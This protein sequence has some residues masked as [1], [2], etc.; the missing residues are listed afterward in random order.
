[1]DAVAMAQRSVGSIGF[2]VCKRE[3]QTVMARLYQAG[4]LRLRLVR[5]E[6]ENFATAVLLNTGGGIAGGD[7][8]DIDIATGIDT[9]L[10]IS[11]QGAE[12]VY[13]ASALDDPARIDVRL[14]VA[15]GAVV[16]FLPQETILFDQ[17]ALTRQTRVE[18]AG[19]G[20]Y[21]G[22]ESLVFGRAAMG[23]IVQHLDFSDR[24]EIIR[25]GR[26]VFLDRLCPPQDFQQA[27]SHSAMLGGAR[28]MA[29]ILLADIDAE[30][31]L[32]AVRAALGAEQA[33]ASAWNQLLVVRILAQ[34]GEALRMLVRRVLNVLREGRAMP[35]VWGC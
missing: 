8:L 10:I 6:Q 11:T 23:E 14:V 34:S 17:A 35:R 9:R 26:V 33:G 2:A 20:R 3:A 21:L 28:A 32:V 7:R 5:A 27:Q 1:M 30:Q 25:D 18:I 13:R 29:T 22:V 31:W 16:E 4:A 15:E 19:A 12:R 24:L